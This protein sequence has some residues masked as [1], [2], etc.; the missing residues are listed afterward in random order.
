[1]GAVLEEAVSNLEASPRLRFTSRWMSAASSK[2]SRR[3]A[4]C[5]AGTRRAARNSRARRG[6]WASCSCQSVKPMGDW[7][8][9]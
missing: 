8:I 5:S 9:T 1:V 2:P 4:G 7:Q 6:R 3:S